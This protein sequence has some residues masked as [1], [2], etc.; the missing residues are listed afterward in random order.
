MKQDTFNRGYTIFLTLLFAGTFIYS[1]MTGKH[2]DLSTYLPFIVP[3]INHA[4]HLIT[5]TTIITT[6]NG[7]ATQKG[8]VTEGH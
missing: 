1:M 4:M 3:T 2:I 8:E 7:N 6:G 5:R